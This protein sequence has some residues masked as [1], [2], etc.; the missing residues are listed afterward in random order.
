MSDERVPSRM[1]MAEY[2]RRHGFPVKSLGEANVLGKALDFI[3]SVKKLESMAGEAS[4]QIGEISQAVLD[5]AKEPDL[6]ER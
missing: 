1:L 3:A 6:Q 4:E 5:M 2:V